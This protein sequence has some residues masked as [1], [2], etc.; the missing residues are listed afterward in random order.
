MKRNEII[1]KN[2]HHDAEKIVYSAADKAFLL[3]HF[4][5]R[6]N[7]TFSQKELKAEEVWKKAVEFGDAEELAKI[8]GKMG[9]E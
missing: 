6:E 9:Y 3:D 4:S 2:E 5:P 7:M 1:L 8:A